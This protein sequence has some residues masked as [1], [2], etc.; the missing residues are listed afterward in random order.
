MVEALDPNDAFI[1]QFTPCTHTHPSEMTQE[2]MLV[3]LVKW[4]MQKF[5][6]LLTQKYMVKKIQMPYK[7]KR[8][9]ICD[10]NLV[11]L[12]YN[13]K[14]DKMVITGFLMIISKD[15]W[16]FPNIIIPY[17][18]IL[19]SVPFLSVRRCPRNKNSVTMYLCPLHQHLTLSKCYTDR[20]LHISR[21]MVHCITDSL[22]NWFSGSVVH[23]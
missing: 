11:C 1:N 13:S 17:E 22:G 16:K 12:L 9:V 2:V 23:F 5:I 19:G 3:L 14:W 7:F 8:C 20:V 18:F 21:V 15:T 4:F 10:E 6:T